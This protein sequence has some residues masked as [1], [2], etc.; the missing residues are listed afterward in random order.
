[1]ATYAPVLRL[2]VTA[3]R[4]AEEERLKMK[5]SCH[6]QQTLWLVNPSNNTVP[7]E[8]QLKGPVW[9]F[10]P[11]D[12]RAKEARGVQPAPATEGCAECQWGVSKALCKLPWSAATLVLRVFLRYFYSFNCVFI[13]CTNSICIHSFPINR[14]VSWY[15]LTFFFLKNLQ[16]MLPKLNTL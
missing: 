15:F 12:L 5:N 3:M 11:R 13:E 6:Q 16:S 2:K 9:R 7:Q 8:C 10:R 1:M 4:G 14:I